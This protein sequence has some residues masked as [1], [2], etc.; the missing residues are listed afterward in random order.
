MVVA[1]AAISSEKRVSNK[2]NDDEEFR[3]KLLKRKKRAM[4][5]K[6]L[7]YGFSEMIAFYN[8]VHKANKV[9]PREKP[10]RQSLSDLDHQELDPTFLVTLKIKNVS[11]DITRLFFKNFQLDPKS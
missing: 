9:S 3:V 8:Y 7:K 5:L 11:L 1:E 4:S 2:R 6:G 10:D